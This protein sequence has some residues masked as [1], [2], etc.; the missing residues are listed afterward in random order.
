M[1]KRVILAFGLTLI[2]LVHFGEVGVCSEKDLVLRG[3]YEAAIDLPRVLFLLKRQANG[4]A[5]GPGG[6]FEVNYAFLDTGGSGIL[7]SLETANL[8]GIGVEPNAR[9]VDIGIGGDEYF[10]VSEPL[11]I[12]LADYEEKNPG[13]PNVYKVL[14][15]GRVQ[16]KKE[17]AG[18]LGQPL[19]I[20]GVPVM[21]GRIV[22]L[23]SGA[24]ND[25]GHFAAEIKEPGDP[26]IPKVDLTVALQFENFLNPNNPKNIPPL[27][28]LSHNPVIDNIVIGYRGKRSKGNWLFDT[29]ATVS[30]ISTD[31][32]KRIG[33]MDKNG[34]PLVTQA[35]SVPVGG[36]GA[37]VQIP[38]FEIDELTVPTLSGRNLVYDKPRLGV[39]DITYF[40]EDKGKFVTLDGVF[41]S[42]FL[43]ATAKMEDL[44][45]LDIGKTAFEKIVLDMRQGLLGFDVNEG[46]R[47]P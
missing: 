22:V 41:G 17:S 26:S 38:G 16:V 43:C 1:R 13:E 6:R 28:S 5:L 32:A 18:I 25:L 40:D 10:D 2:V 45:S 44:F 14:G 29:G 4:P 30:F 33:L 35:F 11:Y 39:H 20:M 23:N 42:N 47:R 8:L 19:D 24:T 27:P 7:L 46:Y 21:A 34:R 3:V 12:G 31:Q 36:V 15:P 9:F 37:M